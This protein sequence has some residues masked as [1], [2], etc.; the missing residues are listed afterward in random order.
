[1][2]DQNFK[3]RK[4]A[5]LRAAR[6]QGIV[7]VVQASSKDGISLDTL[8]QA[9]RLTEKHASALFKKQEERRKAQNGST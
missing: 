6:A 4:E 2:A 5:A 7:D 1:M 8:E 3:E 9:T